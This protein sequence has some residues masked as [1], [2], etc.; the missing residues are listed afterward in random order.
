MGWLLPALP[1][2]DDDGFTTLW[3]L[4]KNRVQERAGTARISTT[5]DREVRAAL[6]TSE[7]RVAAVLLDAF[8]TARPQHAL[9]PKLARGLLRD[10][11]NGRWSNTQTNAFVLLALERYFDAYER[12]ETDGSIRAWLDEQYGGEHAYHG[13]SADRQFLSM[14]L[15]VTDGDSRSMLRLQKQGE[16]RIYYR[17]G[18]RYRRVASHVP[19]LER[20]FA[21]HRSY[22]SLDAP[23][24]VDRRE[25]GRWVIRAGAR[26]RIRL[27]LSIHA[28]RYHVA[29]TDRLPAGL[30]PIHTEMATTRN[31]PGDSEDLP[32]RPVPWWG[33]WYEHHNLRDERA[34]VFAQKITPGVYV[35]TY[36]ARAMTP[37]TYVAPPAR[38]E[39]MYAPE[40]CGRT[41]AT[42]VAVHT[43]T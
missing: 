27:E 37:G 17:I 12:K 21:L 5:Y 25:D 34:E 1:E 9:V 8:L 20:G 38:A 43:D 30:E 3:N 23:D 39:E 10:R 42:T 36:V 19:A 22:A 6:M 16:G 40:T 29:L 24:D 11:S 33:P 7:H 15:P 14:P 41:E 2:H 13:G 31:V 32:A 26:V 4:L 28:P 18:L 35:F